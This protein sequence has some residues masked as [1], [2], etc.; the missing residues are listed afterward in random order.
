MTGKLL[1]FVNLLL[2]TLIYSIIMIGF[3]LIFKNVIGQE[4]V[5][6]ISILVYFLYYFLF[7]CFIGQTPAKIITHSKVVFLP[8]NDGN[9]L[10]QILF[11]TIMRFLPLDLFSYLFSYR[12]LHDRISKT[13]IIKL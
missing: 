2:D 4:H 3:I 5:K 9:Y 1:R 11:R 12:G 8:K 10:I 6:W 7:E 13:T